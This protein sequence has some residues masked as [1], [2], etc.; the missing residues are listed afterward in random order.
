MFKLF[1]ELYYI[2]LDQIE[3]CVHIDGASGESQ[4][5]V[6]KYELIKS[7]V[8]TLLTEANEVDENL[9]LN[10]SELSIPFKLA[11]NTLMFKKIINKI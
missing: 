7:M 1:N 2:D 10:S 9:G 8:E 3:S 11:F 5:H 6:V 4:V